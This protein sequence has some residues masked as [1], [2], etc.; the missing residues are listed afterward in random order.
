[1]DQSRR[2]IIKDLHRTT[3]EKVSVPILPQVLQILSESEKGV[4]R[5]TKGAN[6]ALGEKCRG[7]SGMTVKLER[8]IIARFAI[9]TLLFFGYPSSP[10]GA[11]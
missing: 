5:H 1:M 8:D 6:W 10:I 7:K 2:L 11:V 9:P 3:A 4:Y